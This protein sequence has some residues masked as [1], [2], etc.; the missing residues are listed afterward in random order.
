[1]TVDEKRFEQIYD[2]LVDETENRS[3]TRN[4]HKSY[5]LHILLGLFEYLKGDNL[6]NPIERIFE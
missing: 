1:M 6:E 2:Y 4:A 3:T 5:M